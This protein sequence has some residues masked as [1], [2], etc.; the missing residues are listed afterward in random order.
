MT[1]AAAAAPKRIQSVLAAVGEGAAAGACREE[2]DAATEVER[3]RSRNRSGKVSFAASVR[4]SESGLCTRHDWQ[5]RQVSNGEVYLSGPK[6][7]N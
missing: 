7:A 1:A 3:G 4:A 6:G 2:G 5:R